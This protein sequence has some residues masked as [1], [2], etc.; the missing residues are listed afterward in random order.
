M[1]FKAGYIV[2]TIAKVVTDFKA[3]LDN[4]KPDDQKQLDKINGLLQYVSSFDVEFPDGYNPDYTELKPVLATLNNI[5]TRGL[6]TRAPI[7]LEKLFSEIN[8]NQPNK[9]EFEFNFPNSTNPISYESIFELL[10]IIEPN[11]EIN[12]AN[13]GGN[14]G[15]SLEWDFIKRHP[16]VKQILESQRD[17]STINNLLQG[18]RTVDFCFTSPYLHWNENNNR[19]EK[20]GRIFEVD[21]PHHSL[22]EYKYYD[23]Y[24]DA[25]AEDEDFKT[26]RFTVEAIKEDKTDFEAL[27]GRKI[28]QNFKNNFNKNIKE[29]LAEYSLIFIPLAVARIQKTILEILFVHPELFNKDK[30]EIAIIERD[31]PCGAIAIEALRELFYNINAILEDKD[32]LPLP[33]ISLTVFENTKWVIDSRLHLQASLKDDTFFKHSQFDIILDHSILRRSNIYN[34]PDFGHHKEKTVRIRSSHYFDTSF[35]MARRVYCADLLQYK[36]LVEKRED[37]SYFP[38]S[39]YE[40]HINFFIQTIFRKVSFRDG[41]LPIISRALQQKPVIGLLP[42]GGGKSLTFQLPTFL[43]PGLCLVV[44]PIKSLMEDQVRVLKQN[45]IDCCEFINSNLKREERVK[46]LI[47]FR[48]GETMFLFVSPERFV[49]QDFR[50]IIRTIDVSKFSLAFSY[51]VIDEVHCVSE[52]GHDFRTTYLMLGKNAQNFAKT[53]SGNDVS[54]IGLTA[55]ASF[56]VLTDIERELSITSEDVNDAVISIDNTIRPELFFTVVENEK[57]ATNFPI[58]SQSLKDT[59]GFAK[60]T[61]INI[62]IESILEKLNS[63]NEEVVSECLKQ[64]FNNFELNINNNDSKQKIYIDKIKQLIL[65]KTEI[66]DINDVISVIFCP[67]TTGTFGITQD[68]NPFPKNKELFENLVIPIDNK[69][70]FMGGDDK[71]K[72]QVIEN[73]QKYFLQ[74]MQGKINYMIC[75]KAFGMGIDKEHIRSICHLNF[76]SSPESYIQEAGRAGRDKAK[77]ICSIFLDRNIYYT[78]RQDFISKNYPHNFKLI[79]DRKKVRELH[80]DYN[81]FQNRI[82]EKYYGDIS[83]LMQ[84]YKK[85][86]LELS[87]DDIIEFNQDK[88]IHEYFHSNSFK[89]IETEAF[90]LNRFINYNEGINTTQLRLLQDKYNQDFDDQVN[91]YLTPE[92]THMGN[93]WLSLNKIPFG[94]IYTNKDLPSFTTN[95]L[96][97]D[98]IADNSKTKFIFEYLM[99]EWVTNGDNESSLY[100]FLQLEI[101]EGLNGGQSLVEKFESNETDRFW[102]KVPSSFKSNNFEGR[103]INDFSLSK[104]SII[105]ADNSTEEFITTL[106]KYSVDFNDFIL[107]IEEQWEVD[108][109]N[110]PIYIQNKSDYRAMYYS[111]INSADV[112]KMIYRLYSIGFVED[113]TIDYNL[114]IFSFEVSKRNKDYYIDKTQSHL[115]K[116]LSRTVTL[117]KIEELTNLTLELSVFETIKKCVKE[118]LLFTYED[119]VKKRKDAVNDLFKFISESLDISKQKDDNLAFQDFWYNHHF[120]DEMYYYFNAKYARV[121][122]KIGYEPYS[123]LDDTDKGRISSWETFEKYAKVLNDQSSFISEC[124][125]MRGSCRRIWRTLY[126]EDSEREYILKILSAFATFGLNNKFYYQEAEDLFIDGFTIFYEQHKSYELLKSKIIN[127]ETY[128]HNSISN[129][130]YLPYLNM[131][132]HKIMLKVNLKFAKNINEQLQKVL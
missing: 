6:P 117:N 41:Q 105:D 86:G 124:K 49:M 48:Y 26:I 45:W 127:F 62:H 129:K 87:K 27:I 50:N 65:N 15:S 17:F 128:L 66:K 94:K 100:N 67:H 118:I 30:I 64:H 7:L 99:N 57:K 130:E 42:T 74:F 9:D 80:E 37:G 21:G 83:S 101:I 104:L 72:K 18:N 96:G 22:S 55:T 2:D 39:K 116:Y 114:G 97:K 52:W 95:N 84:V 70:Y 59:I 120:K 47:D 107:R 29:H 8:L 69:G 121:G 79:A 3:T 25:I 54:L 132:K 19:Y 63:I 73:A 35:G 11:L 76:S 125:M 115:L 119:I 61:Q 75:T 4:H 14:L 85:F 91:F 34:E 56:D 20:V 40:G 51:C 112:S 106:I 93:L 90:Q 131:A 89:G 24:R 122:F 102:F 16:F 58:L 109:L 92:G 10:H 98:G 31:L 88:S 111:E 1:Q 126:K 110:N 28:Y 32:K 44:D 82:S 33:Q 5:I 12:G 77:S 78:V 46:K 53:K 13:Y 36:S 113:Y 23:A 123:L 43:Q 108:I 38:V 71:I 81:S 60:Q 103:L 68:A